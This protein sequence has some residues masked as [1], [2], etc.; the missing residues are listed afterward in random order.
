M[1]ERPVSWVHGSILGFGPPSDPLDVRITVQTKEA[2]DRNSD[3]FRSIFPNGLPSGKN[4][5]TTNPMGG[6]L[7]FSQVG[8]HPPYV[9]NPYPFPPSY[10][11]LPSQAKHNLGLNEADMFKLSW[12]Y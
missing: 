5:L 10:P 2:V 12:I 3:L 1:T 8:F 7:N 9:S 11:A 4:I 6:Q